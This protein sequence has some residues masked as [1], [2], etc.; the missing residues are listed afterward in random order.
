MNDRQRVNAALLGQEVER[1]PVTVPYNFLY[2][3]DH[4][5]ELTGRPQ[6]QVIEWLHADPPDYIKTLQQLVA[7][8]PFDFIQPEDAPTHA[9]RANAEFV[10]RDGHHYLHH[11]DTDEMEL[12]DTISGFPVDYAA[13]ET[14]RVFARED[15]REKVKVTPAEEQI[16]R[17]RMDYVRATVDTMGADHFI[18]SGGVIGTLYSS[19]AYVGQS[20]ALAMLRTDPELMDYLSARILEQN[21]E[22]IRALAAQGGDGIYIDDATATN[23]MISVKDYERFSLPYM[24]A[25]V[26]EIHRLNHKAII[27]YFGGVADRLEQIAAIGADGL[28]V[29][30]TMKGYVNDID[31]IARAIGQRVT[32]FGN[33]DPVGVL[34]SADDETLEREMRRQA[35][36]GRQ[37]RGFI[38][39]TGSPITPDTPISRVQ[40]FLELGSRLQ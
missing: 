38:M 27:I 6:H 25:M 15:V 28:S 14:Q 2:Y 9:E 37:A 12:L 21:I 39:S 40:Y 36:A 20:N 31:E 17:G 7:Q 3:R 19:G 13:N 22:R 24:K 35:E 29:E 8:A 23:D 26:E 1:N 30:T 32:I 4:F 18:L 33:I 34:E 11:R 5:N 16:A 10:E